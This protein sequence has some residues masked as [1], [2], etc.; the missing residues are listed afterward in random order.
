[1]NIKLSDF[2]DIYFDDKQNELKQRTIKNKR[3]M[4]EQHIIPYFGNQKINE[5]TASQIIQWQNEMQKKGFSEAYLRM[6]QNQLTCLFSHASRIY[7][8]SVNPCKKVKSMGSFDVRS[9]NFWTKEEY[10]KFIQTI[11]L[12]TR[13]YIIFE[14]LF[15]KFPEVLRSS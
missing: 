7:D 10:D 13:Y 3:Y 2:V 4:M 11:E 15:W 8:L 1:M 12:G 14:I 6:I 9:L 5:I